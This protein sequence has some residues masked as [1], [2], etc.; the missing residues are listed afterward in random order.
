MELA[1]R[2]VQLE[3]SQKRLADMESDLVEMSLS[4]ENYR[5][6]VAN[7]TTKVDVAQSQLKEAKSHSTWINSDL[8]NV[9]E[10]AV[11]L[12]SQKLELQNQ[13]AEQA[14][15]IELLNTEIR[16]LRNEVSELSAQI[17]K[18]RERS[19]TLEEKLRNENQ[20]QSQD[21]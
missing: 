21:R 13:I 20:M 6:Q 1:E 12:N 9:H 11:Q 18:E 16:S 7:L 14:S 8:T 17:Q 19:Q 10:L 5:S 2:S 4:N 3:A 15:E